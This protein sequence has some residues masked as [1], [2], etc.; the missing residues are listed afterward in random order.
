MSDDVDDMRGVLFEPTDE[1]RPLVRALA[2]FGVV[3]DNI[4]KH[5]GCEPKTLRK[6]FGEKVDRGSVEATAQVAQS[7]FQM[8]T[9][10]KN[11]A[12]AIF[13]MKCRG[14]WREKAEVEHSLKPTYVIHS[15]CRVTG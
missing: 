4:A 14:G 11:V 8:A 2:G 13:R 12:A 5:V 9:S 3:H 15:A 7:L 1:Q 10:G 6:H